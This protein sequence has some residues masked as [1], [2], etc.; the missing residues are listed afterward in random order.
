[1]NPLY[2]YLRLPVLLRLYITAVPLFHALHHS[3]K[4]LNYISNTGYNRNKEAGTE[5]DYFE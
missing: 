4:L 2:A 5:L 3:L 1:M